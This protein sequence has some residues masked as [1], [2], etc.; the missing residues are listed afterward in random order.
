MSDFTDAYGTWRIITQNYYPS[1]RWE[2]FNEFVNLK[3][4]FRFEF[5]TDWQRWTTP[6][7]GYKSYGLVRFHYPDNAGEFSFVSPQQRF[8]INQQPILLNF[9][10]TEELKENP[11]F[12]R[13]MAICRKFWRNHKWIENHPDLDV[14]WNV[15]IL[16]FV[17]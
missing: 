13:K 14:Q 6:Y 12:A 16:M 4:L 10:C 3:S 5:N 8:Y 15:K 7:A 1:T 17:E 11:Y 2:L 9:P